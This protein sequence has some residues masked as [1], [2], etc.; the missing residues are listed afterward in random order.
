MTNEILKPEEI[1]KQINFAESYIANNHNATKAYKEVYGQNLSDEVASASASRLLRNVK[2]RHYIK[3][4]FDSLQLD[5]HYVMA[6]LKYLAEN[7]E[8]ESVRLKAIVE[9]AKVLGVYKKDFIEQKTQVEQESPAI[10]KFM[11]EILKIQDKQKENND[12][13]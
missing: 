3:R 1:D 12:P 10:K 4:K 8:K 9:I 11:N 6:R 5:A 2:V 7:A 13:V